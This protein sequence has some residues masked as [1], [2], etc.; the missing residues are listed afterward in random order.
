LSAVYVLPENVSKLA[1]GDGASRRT[2]VD[3][4]NFRFLAV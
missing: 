1:N 3:I 2:V 4:W